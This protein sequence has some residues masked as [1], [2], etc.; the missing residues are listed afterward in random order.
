MLRKCGLPVLSIL[1]E[2]FAWRG[3]Y[4]VTPDR[5]DSI[6]LLAEVSAVAAG[7]GRV[8]QYRHK[9]ASPVLRDAQAALLANFCKSAGV[10]FII[11]DD[12]DLALKVGADGVHLGGDD[13]DL[14]EA[15]ARLGP[16]RVLGVSCY[17]DIFR[18]REALA[19]GADYVALG[20]MFASATKPAAV[21]ASLDLLT[22]VKAQYACPVVTI[23]GITLDNAALLR[24][25]GA[26]MVAVVTDLF[27][28]PDIRS[29]AQGY[30]RLFN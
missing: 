30:Q 14:R 24:D 12:L 4:A 27:E 23:G 15:R 16:G 17:N 2:P 29:R 3:L 26:D 6:R 25:A 20:A 21:R 5:E 1:K 11:N 9:T 7:G 18:V 10:T 8:V 19:A 28:A 22:E 13:G